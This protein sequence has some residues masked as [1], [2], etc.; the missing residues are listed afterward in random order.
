MIH[1]AKLVALPSAP[2]SMT[3]TSPHTVIDIS[4]AQE[5]QHW[6]PTSPSWLPTALKN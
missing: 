4:L 6:K 5:P 2:V 1:T 3:R